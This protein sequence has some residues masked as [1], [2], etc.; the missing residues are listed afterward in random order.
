[1]GNTKNLFSDYFFF[2]KDLEKNL[3]QVIYTENT[4]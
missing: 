3:T 1:M 2:K 4:Y